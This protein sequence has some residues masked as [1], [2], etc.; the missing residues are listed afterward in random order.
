M[1]PGLAD[2]RDKDG[3]V[4]FAWQFPPPSASRRAFSQ[5][6][7]WVCEEQQDRSVNAAPPLRRPES[8]AA[9]WREIKELDAALCVS[10]V[11]LVRLDLDPRHWSIAERGAGGSPAPV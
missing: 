3:P 8:L 9:L 10:E 7:H 2:R 11:T 6:I 5:L 4:Y 1:L